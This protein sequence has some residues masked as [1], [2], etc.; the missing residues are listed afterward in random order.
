MAPEP[1]RHVDE[2]VRKVVDIKIREIHDL[3]EQA[4]S[5]MLRRVRSA[6]EQIIAGR[7]KRESA[8]VQAAQ[9]MKTFRDLRK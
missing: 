6:R 1:S 9:Y 5:N 8:P 4:D 3:Y 7:P 2:Y